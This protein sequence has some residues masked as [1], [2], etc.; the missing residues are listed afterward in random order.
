M[1]IAAML[2]ILALWIWYRNTEDRK[3]V[4]GKYHRAINALYFA[5]FVAAGVFAK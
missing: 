3:P 5:L 4:T 1:K 2:I